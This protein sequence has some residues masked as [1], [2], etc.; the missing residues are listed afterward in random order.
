MDIQKA[1]VELENYILI[2]YGGLELVKLQAI[3]CP[4]EIHL[5]NLIG[6]I[7]HH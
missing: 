1:I 4:D 7:L 6:Y 3:S 2:H 5:K